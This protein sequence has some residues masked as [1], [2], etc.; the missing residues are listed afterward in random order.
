MADEQSSTERAGDERFRAMND[1]SPVRLVQVE[2]S[3][4]LD[5]LNLNS[6]PGERIWVEVVKG[7]QVVGMVERSA[8]DTG[9]ATSVLEELA[10]EYADFEP[11]T[12]E[13]FPDNLLPRA[14]IVV[15]T[16]YRRIDHLNR[17]VE[18]LL[19]LDYPDFEIVVVDNRP[20]TNH[21]PIPEFPSN[22]RV[23][24]VSEPSRGASAAR[25]RGIAETTG[26]FIAFT[27]DDVLV[28]RNWLRALGVRFALDEDVDAIGGMV[29]PTSLDTRPQLW[30]EEFYGGFT[31]SFLAKKWSMKIVG[32]SDPL[33][34]YSAGHFGAGCNMAVRRS[35]FQKYGDF[36][37]L[38]GIGTHSKS[39]ED[40][41]VFINILL[42]GGTVMYE[43]TAL[44]RH[45]HRRTSHEFMIQ[46]FGYG[47]GLTAMY[48]SLVVDDPRRLITIL[49]RVPLG[50]R[51]LLR[52]EE[53]RSPSRFTSFPRRT[54]VYHLLGMAYGPVAYLR[55]MV[56]ARKSRL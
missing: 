5:A 43:P 9:L 1:P 27:D 4:P 49:R 35:A 26:E 48:T 22:G 19:A 29:R 10:D 46:I 13:T 18:S 21:E 3:G 20:G 47:T 42:G 50:L 54:K 14:S 11:S 15:P 7:G 32:D 41:K 55:S 24:V 36:D 23:R 34:P 39:G 51:M 37:V 2:I 52:P 40:L 38:V 17:T 53:R 33:F 30:F 44:V 28:E 25:N 12:F 16:I 45:S 6:I 56:S 8:D 31:K